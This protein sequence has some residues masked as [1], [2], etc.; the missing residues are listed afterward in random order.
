[1]LHLARFFGQKGAWPEA[2]GSTPTP[3]GAVKQIGQGVLFTRDES[4]SFPD[5]HRPRSESNVVDSWHKESGRR[6]L[7]A[8]GLNSLNNH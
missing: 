5:I 2:C 6:E 1:M 4:E 3:N 7:R 8:A